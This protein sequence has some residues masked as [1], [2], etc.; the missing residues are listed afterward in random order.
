MSDEDRDVLLSVCKKHHG[1]TLGYQ[2]AKEA[3]MRCEDIGHDGIKRELFLFVASRVHP[4]VMAALECEGYGYEE[5][6]DR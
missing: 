3:L 4:K 6:M 1:K 5:V 2:E